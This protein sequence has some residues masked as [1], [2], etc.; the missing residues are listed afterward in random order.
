MGPR[1]RSSHAAAPRPP[2]GLSICI[3]E[4]VKAPV[5]AQILGN[6]PRTA[7]S[8]KTETEATRPPL[9]CSLTERS[10]PG[11]RQH[12]S[13]GNIA[14]RG[15][16]SWPRALVPFNRR[17]CAKGGSV[18]LPKY[19]GLRIGQEELGTRA[20]AAVLEARTVCVKL[21]EPTLIL[22]NYIPTRWR[23]LSAPCLV[24]EVYVLRREV[25]ERHNE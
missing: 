11:R 25:G 3:T 20:P 2:I 19:R 5:R 23:R 13:H 22:A 14:I 16:R 12:Y 6:S 15:L 18:P 4:S 7:Q 1:N 21:G 9:A 10:K 8:T 17:Q 24:A